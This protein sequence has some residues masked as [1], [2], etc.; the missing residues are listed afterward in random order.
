MQKRSRDSQEAFNRIA[1]ALSKY[2]DTKE[3]CYGRR[4]IWVSVLS[5][6][7]SRIISLSGHMCGKLQTV[8][9]VLVNCVGFKRKTRERPES[10]K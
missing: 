5:A 7:M 9:G 2:T 10:V 8:I 6:L 4:I 3:I 1:A